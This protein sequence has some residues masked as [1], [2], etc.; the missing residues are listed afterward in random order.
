MGTKQA[1]VI[2]Q[3]IIEVTAQRLITR[4]I[5]AHMM[6]HAEKSMAQ[7]M[8]DLEEA[9]RKTAPDLLPLPGVEP[10]LQAKASA[11]IKARA[12]AMVDGIGALVARPDPRRRR[13][14]IRVV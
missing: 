2:E 7:V 4:A 14:N 1:D 10:E 3:L 5:I 11:V 12:A 13:G 9:V 6:A 8:E